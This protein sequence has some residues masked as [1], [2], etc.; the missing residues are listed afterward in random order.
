LV[1]PF[2]PCGQGGNRIYARRKRQNVRKSC[3]LQIDEN[4]IY[5]QENDFYEQMPHPLRKRTA[6]AQTP[7]RRGTLATLF[8]ISAALSLGKLD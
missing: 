1:L 3:F 4:H 8:V 6:L 5:S 2:T 7:A